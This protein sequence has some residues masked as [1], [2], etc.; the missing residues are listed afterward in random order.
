MNRS[1]F[2]IYLLL[3]FLFAN[4]EQSFA[5]TNQYLKDGFSYE[6][7]MKLISV[8]KH[9]EHKK[10]RPEIQAFADSIIAI[11]DQVDPA[12]CTR[13]K[14]IRSK[15]YFEDKDF[16]NFIPLAVDQYENDPYLTLQDSMLYL[17]RLSKA[18]EHSNVYVESLKYRTKLQRLL[19]RYLEQY[20]LDIMYITNMSDFYA[21]QGKYRQ[22]LAAYKNNLKTIREKENYFHL[23]SLTN[24]VGVCYNKVGEPDSAIKYFNRARELYFLYNDY[25]TNYINGL[26]DGNIAQA[27]MTKNEYH[28]AIPLLKSD[29]AGSRN[30]D[31]TNAVN[32][33][34]ELIRCYLQINEYDEAYSALQELE[35]LTIEVNLNSGQ[36][37]NYQMLNAKVYTALGKYELAQ[38]Y[39]MNYIQLN[40]EINTAAEIRQTNALLMVYELEEKQKIISTQKEENAAALADLRDKKLQQLL[41]WGIMLVIAVILVIVLLA[42]KKVND[43]REALEE[44]ME[45]SN[46]ALLQKEVLLKEIHHRVKNN[47]QIMS[48]L[49]HLQAANTDHQWMK[50]NMKE[51]QQRIESMT[52]IHN[53][54]YQTDQQLSQVDIG[55]YLNELIEQLRLSFNIPPTILIYNDIEE[56]HVSLDIAVPMGLIVN[57][58]ITNSVKYAFPSGEGKIAI[59]MRATDSKKGY[60]IEYVDNGIGF[61]PEVVMHGSSLGVKLIRMFCEEMDAKLKVSSISG[62]H[63]TFTFV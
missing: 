46:D 47:L 48:G 16:K 26:I 30:K 24:S 15:Y 34:V 52:L 8:A 42:N 6:Q 61:D 60:S 44:Q 5:K 38:E 54:L 29:I 36:R 9:K 2:K 62:V 57:E 3:A 14:V 28:K 35:M 17:N 19:P 41:V 59:S 1:L 56:L 51:G 55:A 37:L 40:K 33:Y 32:S 31:K 45:I 10:Y 13:A 21:I 58:L 43:K 49:M 63:Y 20:P 12:D 25:D 7:K 23:G 50:D 39:L 18:F 53:M 22:A 4:G 27:Y 11:C